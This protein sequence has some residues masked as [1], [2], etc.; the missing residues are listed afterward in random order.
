[1]VPNQNNEIPLQ[2]SESENTYL[3]CKGHLM[4]KVMALNMLYESQYMVSYKSLIEMKSLTL[5]VFK[6]FAKIAFCPLELG[7]R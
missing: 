5:F 1:M 2:T 3:T 4:L 7:P 6:I